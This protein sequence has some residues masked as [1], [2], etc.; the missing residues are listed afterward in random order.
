MSLEVPRRGGQR[1]GD[2]ARALQILNMTFA[3]SPARAKPGRHTYTL[4]QFK[5]C[6]AKRLE[7]SRLM[8]FSVGC[9]D[10]E[11]SSSRKFNSETR[12][13]PPSTHSLFG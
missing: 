6:A 3:A 11:R 1:K 12:T 13:W 4:E 9:I 2:I 7:H 5:M 10:C 8:H